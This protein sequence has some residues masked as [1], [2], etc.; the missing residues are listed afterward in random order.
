MIP[1]VTFHRLPKSNSKQPRIDS[2][3][4]VSYTIAPILVIFDKIGTR[5]WRIVVPLAWI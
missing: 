5:F 2:L 4:I 3:K 1:W